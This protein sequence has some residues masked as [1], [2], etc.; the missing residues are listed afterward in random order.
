MMKH[1]LKRHFTTLSPST[2]ENSVIPLFLFCLVSYG[3][4]LYRIQSTTLERTQNEFEIASSTLHAQV[5]TLS[6][7]L[8]AREEENKKLQSNLAQAQAINE[9]FGQQIQTISSTVSTLDKLSKTDRE[10]LQKYSSVYFLNENYIPSAL[11][12]IDTEFLQRPTRQETINTSVKPYLDNLLRSAHTENIDILVLSAYRS[13]NTQTNLKATYRMTYG[14]TAANKF[15]ADQGYSEHQLGSTLDFTTSKGGETLS[16]FEKTPAYTWL[17]DYAHTYGF[18]LSYPQG[19]T[20]Y[21]FEPW[22]WRFVGVELATKIHNEKKHFYDIDQRE[23]N[24]YLSKI[25]D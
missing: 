17:L 20:F 1:A 12:P 24:T 5:N 23:I 13:Y 15:S 25:F 22:H 2:I 9:S 3:F 19:N 10:L 6:E 16:G 4:Y 11:S 14:T 8:F 18:I 7:Q 21:Q